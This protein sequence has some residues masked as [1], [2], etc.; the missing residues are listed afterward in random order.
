MNLMFEINYLP[1][2]ILTMNLKILDGN[3][4]S[5][6]LLL[7]TRQEKKL[8]N[9]FNNNMSTDLKLSKTQVCK[10]LQSGEFLGSLLSKLADSLMKVAI[11]LAKNDL[12]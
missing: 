1:H 5:H 8:K 3:Y 7:T 9:A 4:L 6:E 2:E 10:I 12:A 11:S